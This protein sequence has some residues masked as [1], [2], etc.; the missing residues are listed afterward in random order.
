MIN[1]VLIRIR[2]VQVLYAFHQNQDGNMT[3]AESELKHSFQKSYDLYFYFLVLMLELTRLY[4]R[5]IEQAKSKLLPTEKDINPNTKLIENLFIKQLENNKELQAYLKER[6]LSWYD[7]DSF[8]KALLNEILASD[9]YKDYADSTNSDYDSDKEFWR[10]VFKQI[11]VKN[12][13]LDALLEDE[14][15]FWNDD[16][17]IIESFVIKTIKRFEAENG[18]DQP[19]LPMFKDDEDQQFA[20]R[21]L[22]ESIFNGKSYREMIAGYAQNWESERIAFMDQI[23]MQIA[24]A[25][26]INFPSI[27]VNVTLNEYIDIAKVYS[28]EKSASFINGILDSIVEKLREEKKI[29]K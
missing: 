13:D 14:S 22:R 6:P 24:L 9:I 5:R 4:E 20:F 10:K 28:T 3:K 1:R 18:S 21:L 16:V 17:E 23:I 25:E 12:E 29:L 15:L 7:N 11:I 27:P 2:I 8:L 26:I 19:L